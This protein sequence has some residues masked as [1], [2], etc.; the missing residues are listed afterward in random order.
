MKLPGVLGKKGRMP[1]GV[2]LLPRAVNRPRNKGQK[3]AVERPPLRLWWKGQKLF[4]RESLFRVA[5]FNRFTLFLRERLVD[6][7]DVL[8]NGDHPLH[9]Q[10]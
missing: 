5:F 3:K 2:P 1:G 4:S 9:D 10:V 8:G 6:F 7:V